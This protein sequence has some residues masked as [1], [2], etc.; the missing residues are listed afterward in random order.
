MGKEQAIADGLTWHFDNPR[1]I[2]RT[3]PGLDRI[4][5]DGGGNLVIVEFKGG[6]AGLKP[7][8]MTNEWVNRE[9][10]L[11]EKKYPGGNPLVQELRDALQNGRLKGRSYLTEI[12]S[13]GR[14][15]PTR[16]VDHGTYSPL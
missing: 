6:M 1:G 14:P 8:Q 12:D 11:L 5:K 13:A 2:E 10:K 16:M 4:F 3:T 9:L 7:G 15:L